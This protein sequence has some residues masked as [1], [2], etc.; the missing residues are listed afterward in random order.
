MISLET[1][2]TNISQNKKLIHNTASHQKFRRISLRDDEKFNRAKSNNL[3]GQYKVCIAK[4]KIIY[5]T[6]LK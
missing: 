1:G 4:G 6:P 3:R 2:F 5:G